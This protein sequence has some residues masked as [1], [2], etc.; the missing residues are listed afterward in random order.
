MPV[1]TSES[2]GKRARRHGNG[3]LSRSGARPSTR[4][5]LTRLPFGS[6]ISSASFTRTCL[7]G[8]ARWAGFSKDDRAK[9]VTCLRARKSCL[10]RN[11]I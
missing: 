4:Y 9:G 10:V 6:G 3:S 2:S 7:G 5:V 11:A 8:R 1:R